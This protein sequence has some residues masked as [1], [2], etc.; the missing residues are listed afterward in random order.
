MNGILSG[1]FLYNASGAVGGSAVFSY[2]ASGPTG[3]TGPQL[4]VS[5]NVI[6]TQ[7]SL[8][9]LGASG[10]AF[11]DLYISGNSVHL[12][13]NILSTSGPSLN[14]NGYSLSPGVTTAVDASQVAVTFSAPSP[15]N[16]GN[17]TV[18]AVSMSADGKYITYIGGATATTASIYVSNNYGT[19]FTQVI[20]N[21]VGGPNGFVLQSRYYSGVSVGSTGQYQT[22]IEYTSTDTT[23]FIT[24][25]GGIFVS[26]DYGVT[27]K[28]TYA[29][30]TT[31]YINALTA[32]YPTWISVAISSNGQVQMVFSDNNGGEGSGDPLENN[33]IVAVLSK[34]KIPNAFAD[35]AIFSA[36]EGS[37]SSPPGLTRVYMSD[38]GDRFITAVSETSN[39]LYPYYITL[40]GSGS[41]PSLTFTDQFNA[42]GE[43]SSPAGI[44][45]SR[46]GRIIVAIDVASGEIYQHI[47]STRTS[48]PLAGPTYANLEGSTTPIAMSSNGMIQLVSNGSVAGINL[49]RFFGK[50]SFTTSADPSTSTLTVNFALIS[51]DGHYSYLID[52]ASN[53][54]RCIV[55]Y[56]SGYSSLP[57]VPAT[58]TNWPTPPS[59]VGEALDLIAGLLKSLPGGAFA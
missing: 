59:S 58:S 6:P 43:L 3:P 15:L 26:S 30:Y 31:Q 42:V 44:S 32:P 54:Y 21:S 35:W 9:D 33:S 56:N 49:S 20:G 55:P 27:W 38:S 47:W 7:D 51:S 28:E 10:S 4:R 25:G 2:T 37:L 50:I 39:A 41:M 13:T 57:Y 23:S 16:V 11:R 36:S 8:Y 29:R 46:D 48:V 22:V 34:E 17:G 52:D 18:S 40:N 14:L 53:L 24:Y 45:M 12:G 1:Q 19:T 5:A